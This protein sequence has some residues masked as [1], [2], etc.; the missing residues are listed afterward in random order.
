MVVRCGDKVNAAVD[1][2]VGVLSRRD[3]REVDLRVVVGKVFV[4]EDALEVCNGEIVILKILDG[5]RERIGVVPVYDPGRTPRDAGRSSAFDQS[6]Q[7]PMTES[8]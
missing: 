3:E 7:S 5:V 2:D 8:V 6:V 1:Y 4:G